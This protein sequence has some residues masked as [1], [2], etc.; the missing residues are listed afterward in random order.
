MLKVLAALLALLLASQVHAQ[1]MPAGSSGQVLC[2]QGKYPTPCNTPLPIATTAAETANGL[3]PVSPAY[4]VGHAFRYL[5]LAQI[6]DVIARTLT[7]DTQAALNNACKAAW[8]NNVSFYIPGGAYSVSAPGISLPCVTTTG[9]G[10]AFVMYGDGMGPGFSTG[11]FTNMTRI[12]ASGTNQAIT[13]TQPQGAGTASPEMYL[14]DLRFEASNTTAVAVAT[15][16]SFSTMER[17][18][19]IQGSTGDG[20]DCN[21]C[22]Y[23]RLLEVS[24]MNGGKTTTGGNGS[25]VG[26]KLIN[27]AASGTSTADGGGMLVKHAITAGWLTSI[28]VGDGVNPME[29]TVIEDTAV[30]A[31]TNGVVIKTLANK[32]TVSRLYEETCTGTAVSDQGMNTTVRDG[33]FFPGFLVGIDGS[34]PGGSSSAPAGSYDYSN[35]VFNMGPTNGFGIKVAPQ[36]AFFEPWDAAF[37]VASNQFFFPCSANIMTGIG[38]SGASPHV[39]LLGNSFYPGAVHEC[40]A[41]TTEVANTSTGIGVIGQSTYTSAGT[42]FKIPVL[43]N[44]GIN[45]LNGYV[46]DP[47]P[48]A[49]TTCTLTSSGAGGCAT[50]VDDSGLGDCGK[51]IKFS[52][53][54]AVTV[55]I[56]AGL[57]VGCQVSIEQGGA[58]KVSVNGTAVTAATLHSYGGYTGTAGQFAVIGVTIDASGI[59]VLTGIGS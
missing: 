55:T 27:S 7:L 13:F 32:T 26:I 3:T 36:T 25:G 41:N 15:V 57:A 43:S 11:S 35:N 29:T 9:Q 6:V 17:V 37:R 44:V 22:F 34:V 33:Y 46:V 8:V 58:G 24:A 1:V 2:Y 54:T 52:S 50:G 16:F 39:T 42:G 5:S 14:R 4:P 23:S 10:F 59:A 21:W 28:Q 47:A 31:C 48:N 40:G 56:P 20:F 53:A 51:L 49:A 19:F 38:I 45:H 30:Q 18:G 12:V